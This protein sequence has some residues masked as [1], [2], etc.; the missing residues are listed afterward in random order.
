MC[1]AAVMAGDTEQMGLLYTYF[2][3]NF[4]EYEELWHAYR[5][6]SF[7]LLF[8]E[9]YSGVLDSI[10]E[11]QDLFGVESFMGWAQIL[12]ANT[13]YGLG[14]YD[15]AEEA[16]NMVLGVSDW[17]GSL[18]AEAM[19]GMGRCRQALED[20]EVAHSFVQRTYLLMKGYD[21]GIWAA[22]GYLGAVDCLVRL[23]RYEDAGKTLDAMMKDSYVNTLPQIETAR[24]LKKKY[25]DA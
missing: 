17:R 20:Y 21:D 18:F 12:K 8:E 4:E 9:D 19:Y 24:E 22:D 6:K 16:Y 1:D 23:G 11:V 7:Q 13:L 10:D 2:L 3:E 5:A 14:E 25:G 15:K